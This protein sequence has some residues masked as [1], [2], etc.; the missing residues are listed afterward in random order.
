LGGES[1]LPLEE[2]MIWRWDVEWWKKLP[3]DG[4]DSG[5]TSGRDAFF[6]SSAAA[7]LLAIAL[8]SPSKA[9]ALSKHDLMLRDGHAMAALLMETTGAADAHLDPTQNLCCGWTQGSHRWR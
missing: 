5:K 2:H 3:L 9:K 7:N 4:G 6:T 8:I 1:T